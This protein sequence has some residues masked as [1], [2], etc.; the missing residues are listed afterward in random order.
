MVPS[1]ILAV[2]ALLKSYRTLGDSVMNNKSLTARENIDHV[3][4]PPNQRIERTRK[5]AS[6]S[7]WPLMLVVGRLRFL[8]AT[9]ELLSDKP[10]DVPSVL[11][12]SA[13]EPCM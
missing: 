5:P 9:N 11:A 12:D 13:Y 1:T 2:V 10:Q 3:E 6:R 8:V 7:S 4:Q